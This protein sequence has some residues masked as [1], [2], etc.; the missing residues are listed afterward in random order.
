M[1]RMGHLGHLKDEY[2]SLID[3]L[4]SGQVGLP[5]PDD[6]NAAAARLEILEL[7][8]SPEDARVASRMPIRP[9][10]LERIAK[11]VGMRPQDLEP[12]L[13]SMCDRGL[14]MD[15]PNPRTGS[16]KYVL[17]PPVVGF[18]EFTMMRANDHRIPQRQVAEALDAY[19][20]GDPAFAREVF[21]HDTV[22]GRALV[23]EDHL[24][25]EDLPD[26]LDWQRATSLV[27]NAKAVSVSQCYCRH[28]AEHLGEACDAPQEICLS[29][30]AGA[31]FVAR[32]EFGRAISPEEG[33]DMLHAAR[34]AGM[35]QIA[36]NVQHRPTYIC[37]CCACC[38]GQLRA[39]NDFDLPGVNPSG[40]VPEVDDPTCKGCSRCS[41][42][43]PVTAISMRAQRAGAGE[44][45]ELRPHV[46]D[47]RCIGCGVC[48]S[49]CKQEALT[50]ARRANQPAVPAHTIE[51]AV[52]MALERGRLAHLLVD[53][54]AEPRTPIPQP[55]IAGHHPPAARREDPR[56]R[57]GALPVH[58]LRDR[59][60]PRSDRIGRAPHLTKFPRQ[61]ASFDAGRPNG[62]QMRLA[63]DILY[64]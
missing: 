28:K 11:Q 58:P 8:Y 62:P 19:T 54:G 48:A 40:F 37:N 59:G 57:A 3:R 55:G 4:D 23:N 42:A 41:R 9:T 43:C 12:R 16:T 18:F 32:R 34:E 38:C 35:V 25:D 24:A 52:R 2:R 36:D 5:Q 45:N 33:L 27:Q 31:E 29:L 46:D 7:L 49:V 14:A 53:Q 50:M 17:A 47:D 60:N 56:K 13:D 61:G 64:G 63:A 30:N 26:V 39:I 10:S 21:G 15:I 51:R 22:V 44:K 6:A 1:L 20:H